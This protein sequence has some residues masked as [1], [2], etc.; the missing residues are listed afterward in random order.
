MASFNRRQFIQRAGAAAAALSY[1]PPTTAQVAPSKILDIPIDFGSDKNVFCDWRFIEA[2]YGLVSSSS[3]QKQTHGGS[4]L[5]PHGIRLR[6]GRPML[7]EKPIIVADTPTDGVYIGGYSTLLE[8]GGKF[9]LWYESYLTLK[10]GDASAQICYAE[11]DDGLTWKKPNVGVFKYNGSKN[12]NV[13]FKHG[14]GA[15]IFIDPTAGS[16]ERYKM[17]HLGKVPLQMVNG[18]Q[19]NSFVFGAVSPDG[20]HWRQLQQPLI[21]HTSDTQSIAEYD[22]ITHKYVAYLR[23]WEPQTKAGF[24]GRR[25][26]VRTESPEFGNFPEPIPVLSMGPQDPPD[27]D[28][29]TNAYQ[30]W[31]GARQAYLMTPAIYHRSSDQVDLQ[32]ATSRD[33]IRWQFPQREPFLADGK[34]GSGYEGAIYA[35]RGTI[36]ISKGTWAFP[37]SRYRGTHNT[38]FEELPGQ[39]AEGS[40]WLAML[41]EDGYISLEAESEGECWTQPAAFTGSQLLINSWGMSGSRV[42]IELADESGKPFP[43]FSLA[44]CDGLSGETLWS[45]MTWRGNSNVGALSGKLIRIRFGLHRVCLHAFRFV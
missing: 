24:G 28:V 23:G 2:G 33:G 12:N 45:P 32:L 42:M 4:F 26:V 30:R 21:K 34:P 40:L 9:R 19:I 18:K 1:G 22:P 8:D 29:Y 38:I 25:I 37:V 31:P 17:I 13:V 16:T 39:P 10:T 44:D 3:E 14:H 20:I 15:S 5:M 7:S 27:V 35:G 11:S 36:P 41:R 43:N 6:T